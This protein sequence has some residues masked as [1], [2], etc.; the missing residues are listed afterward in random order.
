MTGNVSNDLAHADDPLLRPVVPFG[1]LAY[2]WP[3][4]RWRE[5]WSDFLPEPV[6]LLVYRQ[7]PESEVRMEELSA[8]EA[9][10]FDV[11][12]CSEESR[13]HLSDLTH[14]SCE[15]LLPVWQIT[16]HQVRQWLLK[17]EVVGFRFQGT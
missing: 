12:S 8:P 11:L 15:L 2:Q 10:V 9:C 7:Y 16:S 13:I 17:R 6:V 3:V 14:W 4:H 5:N 1:V